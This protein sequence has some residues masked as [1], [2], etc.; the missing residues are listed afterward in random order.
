MDCLILTPHRYGIRAV[1]ESVG[2]QWETS[3]YDVEYRFG[4]GEPAQ[5]GGVTVGIPGIERWWRRQF[6]ELSE[7]GE[8]YDLLWMHQP[9]S[10]RVPDAAFWDRT[11]LTV[12]TTETA[13]YRL[14]REGVY[15]RRRLP[16]LMA[17]SL[18]ERWFHRRVGALDRDGPMYTVVAPHLRRE[19]A[20]LGV[21][22]AAHVTNG[23][24]EPMGVDGASIRAEFDVPA[25]ATLVFTVGS[26][27]PQKRPVECATVLNDACSSTQDLHTVIAGD[28]PLHGSVREA[29]TNPRVH[30]RGYVEER[31]KWRWF[32]AADAFVSYAAYEGL[33]VAALEAL[34]AGVPVV[35]S[36]V[37]AHRNLLEAYDGCG[38][39]VDDSVTQLLDAIQR[40]A[41]R[42][43]TPE[44]PSW[45]AVAER[46]LD[47]YASKRE[48]ERWT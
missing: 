23:R 39:L 27:T 5:I 6:R 15:P 36:D 45:G 8:E 29:A 33:P 35:L 40:L 11:L 21:S 16:Y 32:E 2:S 10:L 14:A 42:T 1:A 31:E 46:Y 30:V 20:D 34:A 44:I 26:Q 4:D 48:G 13:E 12:H 7:R 18:L 28:G 19:L 47:T 38:T 9:L 37:P 43:V 22:D 3:G 24:P 17:T 41:D 25:D